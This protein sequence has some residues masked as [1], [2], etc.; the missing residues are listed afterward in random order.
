MNKNKLIRKIG[1]IIIN[2]KPGSFW[3]DTVIEDLEI[4]DN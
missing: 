4:S 3:E 1:D 2:S